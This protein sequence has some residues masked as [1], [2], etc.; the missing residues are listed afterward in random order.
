MNSC[1]GNRGE[2]STPPSTPPALRD[3]REGVAEVAEA[4]K[5]KV[6]VTEVWS[7]FYRE[8]KSYYTNNCMRCL[9]HIDLNYF[10]NFKGN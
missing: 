5:V 6:K 1:Q 3:N 4:A 7:C 9:P 8:M 2:G 10:T